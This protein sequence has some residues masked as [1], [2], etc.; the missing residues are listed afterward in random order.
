VA[1]PANINLSSLTGGLGTSFYSGWAS[2]KVGYTVS[3]GDINGDGFS[4]LIIGAPGATTNGTG[5]GA[6][7][8]VFGK[9]SGFA[10]TTS[11]SNLNGADGFVLR[12]A[13]NEAGSQSVASIGDL[14]GDGY[15]DLIIGASTARDAN[16]VEKGASYV[17][18]GKA[19]GFASS[20][21]LSTL[22]GSNGFKLTGV[23][24]RDLNGWSVAAAGDVNKDGYDDIIIGA[25]WADP[26]GGSS[27]ASYVVFGKASGFG[28]NFDLSTLN[29]SNGF[30]MSGAADS[31]RAGTWV[32]SAGDVNGDGYDDVIVGAPYADP[33]GDISGVAYVVFGR[34]NG[35]FPANLQLSSLNGVG[36]FKLVGAA[37]GDQAGFAVT[38]GGDINGD[39]IDDLIVAAPAADPHG[40]KSGASYVVFGKTTGFSA[41]LDLGTLNGS[42]GFKLSGVAANDQ[43]GSIASAG[44]FNGDGYDDLIIGARLADPNGSDSGASYV[45]FGK[46]GGFAA[47][48]DLST[49]DGSNG[50]KLSGDG[51][52]GRSG[53][54][55]ASA[56]DVNGDGY[57]DLIIGAPYAG[58][59]GKTYI[60]YGR[61]DGPAV[62]SAAADILAG[63]GGKDVLLGGGGADQLRGM[64]GD[65]W[66]QVKDLTFG[67]A[68]GGTGRDTLALDG[69]GLTLDLADASVAAKLQGIEVIEL[70]GSGDNTLIVSQAALLGGGI[71]SV[72]GGKHV[73]IVSGNTGD[74]VQFSEVGWKLAGS[75]Y[76]AAEF[77]NY[78]RWVFGDAEV[79]MRTGTVSAANSELARLDG[80]SGFRLNGV[81]ASDQSG[82]SVASAG[83]V[84][85]D[86]FADM[87]VGA[88][89]AN[90]NN[91]GASY[92]VFGKASGFAADFNLATLNGTNGFKLSGGAAN[93]HIGLSVAS[94][95]DMNGDGFVDLIVGAPDADPSGNGS[96]AAY[97]AF[98]KAS[99]FTANLNLST[100]D[101]ANGFKLTGVAAAQGSGWSVASAGDFN[102]DG[103]ADMIV[104]SRAASVGT[105]TA[106]VV[107]GKASGF[108]ATT[109]LASLDGNNGFRLTGLALQDYNGIRVASAG[110][111]NGDGLD[112]L[113]VGV[114]NGPY[115]NAS[116]VV[117]G[118]TS[119]VGDNVDLSALD[120]NNGFR[121]S[122]PAW[123]S[124]GVSVASAGDVNGDG[125]ADLIVGALHAGASSDKS[126]A[127]YVVFGKAAGFSA[128]INLSAL[129]GSNGFKLT[130]GALGDRAG[131]SVASAGDFN[132]DGY[133]DL[134]IGA[135][136]ADLG[137]SGSGTTYVVFGKASGFA[138]SIDLASLDASAGFALRG[139]GGSGYSVASAGDVNKDG[140]DDLIIGAAFATGNGEFSG[141]SYV[142]FG[143][144][145]GGSTEPVSTNGTVAAE[146]LVGGAGNDVLAGRGGGDV[147][148]AGA[149]N[150]R[151]AVADLTFRLADGG[152]GTDT[153]ALGGTGLSLD[154]GNPLIAAKLEGIE[155]IDLGGIGNTLIVSQ[156]GI[157]GGIGAVVGGMHVLVVERNSG[158][159]VQFV[160]AGWAKS[161]SLTNVDGIFDRWVLG[162]AEVHVEQDSAVTIIGTSGDD[163]ISPT[164]SV[165]GQPL[166]TPLGDLIDGA[167]GADTMSG[168]LGDDTYVVDNT[169][170]QVIELVGDG[171][172]LVRSSAS[173]WTLGANVENLTLTGVANNAGTGNGLANVLTGNSGNNL[174]DGAAGADTMAGGSGDD[175]YVVDNAG[176]V[177]AELAN[178]GIDTALASVDWTLG[179]NVEKLTLTGTA[180]LAGTG[181][182]LANTLTGNTGN[183]R[184]NGAA[185]A[186]T[187]AGGLGNDT[188][189]VDA[190]GDVVTENAGEGTDTVEAWL[191]WTLG[192]NLEQLR[193][194]GTADLNGTGNTVDNVLWGNAGKNVLDGKAGADTMAGGLGD[195]TYLVDVAGDGVTEAAGEGTDT[196]ESR[197]DWT[198]GANFERLVLAG[199]SNLK[200]TGNA[201]ANT[202]T[203]NSGN[204]LLDGGAGADTMAG[205]L[206]NDTY[207]VDNALDVVSEGEGAGVDTVLS[208]LNWILGAN[209][210]RL[211]LT[212]TAHRSGTGNGLANTLTGNSGN[213]LLDGGA[214]ADTMAGGLGD[215]TYIVDEAGDVTVEDAGAGTDTVQ[216]SV[217]LRLR[218]NLEKLVLTGSAAING[219]GN[220]L[221][222]LLTGNG[223]NN[224]LDGGAGADAMTGGLGD[225]TYVIDDAEDRTNE[226]AGGG[227]D[228]VLSSLSHTL[229]ANLEKLVLTGTAAINGYG[230]GEANGL[231]GNGA[232][233]ILDGRAGADTMEGRAGN[234]TYMVD[235]AG[236]VVIEAAGGGAD[237]VQSSVSHT[238]SANVERLKLV[239]TADIDAT[240]NGL[241][242]NLVGNAGDN[243][244]DGGAGADTMAGGLGDDTYVIDNAKDLANENAG[245]GID[246]VLSSISL[247]LK[248]NLENLVLTGNAALNGNGNG[249]ANVLTGNGAANVLDGRAGADTMSGGGGDD[250]YVIDDTGDVVVELA[251]GGTDM[252]QSSLSHALGAN[253]ERLKLVGT[254]DIDAT[255]NELANALMGNGGHNRLDGGLG[256]DILAGGGGGDTFRFS[257]ALGPDNVD[258]ITAF[259][260]AADTIQLDDAIFA[261]LGLG[262]LGAGAFNLGMAATQADDRILFH[263]G[264]KSLYYDADGLGGGA[265]VKFATF[266]ALTGAL[267]HTDFLI[268]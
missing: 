57:D 229:R 208:S 34:Q 47:N 135:P 191:G 91:S 218:A 99:G 22:N 255:G 237:E 131:R 90:A 115:A 267:D 1:F 126:G 60:V 212:G 163:L 155:R 154:L 5:S 23:T 241:A 231:T 164:V 174:L 30:K 223:A 25:P 52:G 78:D 140:Y 41:S 188:Y 2:Q 216:S 75:V 195:D 167:A 161:G 76:E 29:G 248:P 92:V 217:T 259:D 201:L 254:A 196:V 13:L 148:R 202:L 6:T 74:K 19:S 9:A 247:S 14:N 227:I 98:G 144:A 4:D 11:L 86:G 20:T 84:N 183:N 214:G 77:A 228:T 125:Y 147:F 235:D 105:A 128:N 63:A 251:G 101:G 111:I 175:T 210:E 168:G 80:N 256:A 141:T 100:L 266:D 261:S 133:D 21:D 17:V 71:G 187:M 186:D 157:L 205:G 132:G 222:N 89:Y 211:T 258:R 44:D 35:I 130:G 240:G 87:I 31:D 220:E 51:S 73:L 96:G 194:M 260:H 117:F 158:D 238:L 176:D 193:L 49:L 18:F 252:V 113:L 243:R 172:D 145:L 112:D 264:S 221:A 149:G 199:T 184:L 15:D 67:L 120:G 62:G 166:A 189:V 32:A 239:G 85:G 104:A 42:N 265:A 150:D 263:A 181:N 143:G 178:G 257:T 28:A 119:G 160:E 152:T 268:V 79:R 137:G 224:V 171:I 230:N 190:A 59:S 121:L 185:G 198:L 10:P 82:I 236:D 253:V 219:T 50:F 38:A 103:F 170:D 3:S 116:Y 70:T 177:V 129:N 169:G 108:A 207:V 12:G 192:V 204:N 226:N 242:N 146:I 249:E 173:I 203:G 33:N 200:G 7:Y 69:S 48:L 45:V 36:G 122:G 8:V 53:W 58:T 134:L 56:G 40:S 225:D 234:D 262:A 215:D 97:V 88:F 72:I 114:P 136:G 46:A 127:S 180:N 118:Q 153:L 124:A 54:S 246:T 162:N 24:Y 27:G 232:N 93:D 179:A 64:A 65:D 123:S 109:S 55:V 209:V 26:N 244:L 213:N 142:V 16:G 81:A 83:D 233:N 68:D 139:E 106:Y 156:L 197:V 138:A 165:P 151:L 95:G 66:L 182:E 61:A 206:G 107:F 102:G 110:D 245:G 39:G 43:S 94:A 159:K 250:T 37:A